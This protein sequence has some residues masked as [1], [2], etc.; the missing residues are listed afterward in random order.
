MFII[1]T[2][3]YGDFAA[4]DATVANA[5]EILSWQEIDDEVISFATNRPETFTT[6][7]TLVRLIEKILSSAIGSVVFK[8]KTTGV[9][10]V[11]TEEAKKEIALRLFSLGITEKSFSVCD[12]ER[13]DIQSLQCL[14]YFH[15]MPRVSEWVYE[16]ARTYKVITQD[17]WKEGASEERKVRFIIEFV[18][19]LSDRDEQY[20]VIEVKTKA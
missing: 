7:E 5:K 9:E 15:N 6:N 18:N 1:V 12:L 19:Q 10:L 11:A 2:R 17:R 8:S 4:W 13:I 3:G 14:S 16:R 20:D